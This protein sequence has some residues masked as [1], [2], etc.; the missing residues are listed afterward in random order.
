MEIILLPGYHAVPIGQVANSG[1]LSIFESLEQ[2]QAEES[3]MLAKLV[4]RYRSSNFE[5]LATEINQACVATGIASWPEHRNIAFADPAQPVI[6]ICWQK[7][8]VW[9]GWI[10]VLIGSVILPPLIMAGLWLILP[11][12][13]KQMLESITYIGI[14]GAMMYIMSKMTTGIASSGETT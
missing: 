4:F 10:L 6:Y 8:M 11:D 1:Q 5:Q 14:M 7:G 3:R 2:G 9:W 13:V 12:S